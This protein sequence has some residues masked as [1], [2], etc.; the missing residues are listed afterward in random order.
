MAWNPTCACCVLISVTRLD[1][2]SPHIAV[3]GGR[4]AAG[5][6]LQQRLPDGEVAAGRPL[7]LRGPWNEL[8]LPESSV[9]R[10]KADSVTLR[11]DAAFAKPANYIHRRTAESAASS[12]SSW[13]RTW[14]GRASLGRAIPK[15]RNDRDEP[16]IAEPLGGPLLQQMRHGRQQTEGKTPLRWWCALDYARHGRNRQ[17]GNS[18]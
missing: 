9:N 3:A 16:E 4:S 1:L 6:Q 13:F 17:N 5:R 11:V 12:A 18:A 2:L 10:P 8:L 15:R 7:L 14:S